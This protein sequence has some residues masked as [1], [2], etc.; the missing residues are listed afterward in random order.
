M[1]ENIIIDGAQI[2]ARNFSGKEGKFNAAGNRNFNLW[3][4]PKLAAA[5]R[6]DGWNVK[7][8][9][10]KSDPDAE[11]RP[12][13]KVAVNYNYIPPKIYRV[14]SN[15]KKVSLDEDNVGNLDWEEIKN[16]R[17]VVRPYHWEVNGKEGIKAYVKTMYV[18]IEEDPFESRYEEDKGFDPSF[19]PSADNDDEVPFR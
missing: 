18:E 9:A 1:A 14:G 12:F 13:I 19:L 6:K 16:V 5:L 8:Y 7:E 3:L 4:E 11:P 10:P 17:I 2:W 15:G